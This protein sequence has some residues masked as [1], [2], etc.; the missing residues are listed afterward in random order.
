MRT[1]LDS[2]VACGGAGQDKATMV[3]VGTV[4]KTDGTQGAVLVKLRH[5]V[6][7]ADV[8]NAG[9]L[10]VVVDGAEVPMRIAGFARRGA[11]AAT[12]TLAN[13]A[14]LAAAERL[15]G[16]A[17]LAKADEV[18]AGD[19]GDDADADPL[20]GYSIVAEGGGPVGAI[21]DVDDSVAA[22]PLFVVR[23]PGGE[24]LMIPATDDFVVCADD[25]SRTL[26]L[27]LPDGLLDLDGAEEED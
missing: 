10:F 24:E 26:V 16:C 14:S 20:V 25:D 7:A 22:N 6:A 1:D 15:V 23:R 2:I 11:H 3:D 12:V 4:T 19:D 17:V 8:L 9:F 18:G 27:R 21:V 13:V 5:G